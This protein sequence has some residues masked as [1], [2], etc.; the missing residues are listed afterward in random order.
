MDISVT[1][2]PTL[3]AANLKPASAVSGKTLPEVSAIPVHETA[4]NLGLW[5]S[6]LESFLRIRNHAFA[7]TNQSKPALRDWSKEL[8]LTH[9]ALQMCSDFALRLGE[10]VRTGEMREEA[11][12]EINIVENLSAPDKSFDFSFEEIFALSCNLKNL[13]LLNETLLRGAPH[14]LG[15][16]ISWSEILGS[17]LRHSEAAAK[18]I[19]SAESE[20]EKHL[21][22]ALLELL[23][24]AAIAS[25][26]EADLQLVL[27]HFAKILKWLEVVGKM[28]EN[29]EPLKLVLLIFA[30]VYEQ[31]QMMMDYIRNRLLRFASEED[32]L[33]EVLDCALY[34][35]SME[36][37]KVFSCELT[38]LA[39]MRQPLSIRA[40]TETSYALLNDCFQLILVQFARFVEPDF[41]PTKLFPN[42]QTKL[43]QSLSLRRNLWS[44]QQVVRRAEQNPENL[45]LEK[46]ND[47]LSA[48]LQI[49]VRFLMFKDCETFERFAEE[50]MRT[51]N[52]KDLVPILHRFGAYLET[53]LGQ[54]N[55]RTVLTNYPF[56][57]PK[58]D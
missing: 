44:M 50:V 14:K 30:R 12:D 4:F 21:P 47:K 58:E 26:V 18:L 6:G 36:L 23:Q 54:V 46:L 8:R 37:K 16:W 22:P 11:E 53:L 38:G 13:I 43:D 20:G 5:L 57:Y 55:M 17:G 35:A 27:P 40:K 45:L 39:E 31:T 41:E 3:T 49:G 34:A 10:A 28:L 25:A 9:L 29:D 51:R 42:F 15:E 24:K 2:T 7:E 32:T 52:K 56:D 19:E 1:S 33:Y 48:F